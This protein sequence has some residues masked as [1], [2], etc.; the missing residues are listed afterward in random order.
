[1]SKRERRIAIYVRVSSASQKF[2]AQLPDLERWA[3][4]QDENVVWYKDKKSGKTMARDAWSKLEDAM[5]V[6]TVS[7]VVVWR[8]D[9]LGRTASGLTTLFDELIE[10]NIN[11]KSLKDSLD[12]STASGRLMENVLASIAQFETEVRGERVKEG[13]IKARKEGKRWGGSKKGRVT[14]TSITREQRE[15]V[16]HLKEKGTKIARIARSVNLS[17]PTI[18]K[19]L[20]EV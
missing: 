9:R 10:R 11:F 12:L 1:M 17:R 6:G 14:S 13:H 4:Q 7:Q 18:Y 5:R 16:K 20:A 3:S 15:A 19:I 8:I 2:A